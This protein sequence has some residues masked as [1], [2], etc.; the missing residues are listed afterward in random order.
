MLM[1]MKIKKYP[2]NILFVLSSFRVIIEL[3]DNYQLDLRNSEFSNLLGFDAK[4]LT[5]TEYGCEIS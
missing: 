5:E 2:I 3:D 4:L 1:M